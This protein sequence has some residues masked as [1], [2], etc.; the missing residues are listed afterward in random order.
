VLVNII[1]AEA[2]DYN[3]N[4]EYHN[5]NYIAEITGPNKNELSQKYPNPFN[6]VTR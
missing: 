3:G 2:I 4:Y 6:P 1:T 5:L